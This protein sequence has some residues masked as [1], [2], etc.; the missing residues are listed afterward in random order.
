M[1]NGSVPAS[2]SLATVTFTITADS[3]VT[4]TWSSAPVQRSLSVASAHGSPSPAVG[5]HSYADGSSVTASVPS[6]VTEGSL[7]WTC[8]GW[9]GTG[10][11]PA[12]GSAATVTF[13]ISADSSVTWLWTSAPV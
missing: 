13:T 1:R 11:V 6:P 12:T 8:T 10:S 4:W 9:T 2:G 5:V 3:S 7:V